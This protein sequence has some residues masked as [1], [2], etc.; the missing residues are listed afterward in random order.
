MNFDLGFA[1]VVAEHWLTGT[2]VAF[3]HWAADD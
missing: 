3:E 2:G 1:S